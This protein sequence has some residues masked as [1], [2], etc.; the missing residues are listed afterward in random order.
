MFW[1]CRS[2][3]GSVGFGAWVCTE[4]ELGDFW[5]RP[6]GYQSVSTKSNKKSE[7]F[8]TNHIT[9]TRSFTVFFRFLD[10]KVQDRKLSNAIYRVTVHHLWHIPHIIEQCSSLRSIST[11]SLEREIGN[12][13][14]KIRARL[15]VLANATN[16]VVDTARFKFLENMEMIDFDTLYNRNPNASRSGFVYHPKTRESG[17]RSYPQLWEPFAAETELVVGVDTPIQGLVPMNLFI[18][19]LNSYRRRFDGS[20]NISPVPLTSVTPAARIWSDSHIHLSSFAKKT[21]RKNT[22]GGEYVMF[23]SNHIN[24]SGSPPVSS[25]YVA[26]VLFYFEY[27][28]GSQRSQ[29]ASFYAIG[30]VMSKHST[31]AHSKSIPLVQPFDDNIQQK[32]YAVFDIADIVSTVGLIKQSSSSKWLYVISPSTAF[33]SDMSRNAG[34]LSHL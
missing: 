8:S 12:Y 14:K 16:V 6:K 30:E 5:R 7:G 21:V 2:S 17:D 27:N 3:Q 23:T 18:A 31:A 11:R 25:W 32:K 20:T 19:A 33:N 26:K 15:D 28:V 34:K 9:S 10:K 4:H 1:R 29:L 24:R 22:R 13:K